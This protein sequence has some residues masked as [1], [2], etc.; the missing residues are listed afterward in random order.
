MAS[1]TP[2]LRLPFQPHDIIAL[3]R[4]QII[5]LGDRGTCVQT[6]CPKLL[7]ESGTAGSRTGAR[8]LSHE[9]NALTIWNK[10]VPK[11]IINDAINLIFKL[12]SV[13]C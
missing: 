12:Q 2:D 3:N 13:F 8:P 1:A 11:I 10:S 7:P 9:P 6:N 5:L 4:Y